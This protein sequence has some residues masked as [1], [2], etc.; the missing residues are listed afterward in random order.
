MARMERTRIMEREN[1]EDEFAVLMGLL[2]PQDS[3]G[4]PNRQDASR[5]ITNALD[6]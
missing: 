6:L 3:T 2:P 4:F 5:R 1:L